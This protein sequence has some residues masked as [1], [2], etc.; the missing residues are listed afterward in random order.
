MSLLLLGL[1]LFIGVHSV[2][3]FA[4]GW[5]DAQIA[6]R[7]EGMWKGLYSG[8]AIISF[9]ILVYGYGLARP[10]AAQVFEP[11]E[12]GRSV[13]FVAMPVAL[14]LFLASQFPAG[15]LK[16]RFKH[17]MLWGTGIWAVAHLLANGDAASVVLFAAILGWV[18][19]DLWSAFQR[20]QAESGSVLVWPDLAALVLG[21][22]VTAI[23]VMY[24]HRWLIGVPVM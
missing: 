10:D 19:L 4:P 13:L 3:I 11:P 20:P 9:A 8:V 12:W 14:V 22:I 2:R 7:G 15:H 23:F 16:K 21:F 17:P 24:L 5:R 6:A 1:T 18:L